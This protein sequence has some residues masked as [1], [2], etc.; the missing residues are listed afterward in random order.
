MSPF[1]FLLEFRYSVVILHKW[2][3]IRSFQWYIKK[4]WKKWTPLDPII[5]MGP[6]MD[7]LIAS[8]QK[9][10]HVILSNK[11]GI[12]W[13]NYELTT[14]TFPFRVSHFGFL[15]LISAIASWHLIINEQHW[16]IPCREICLQKWHFRSHNCRFSNELRSSNNCPNEFGSVAKWSHGLIF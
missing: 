5:K 9:S 11:Y 3:L 10:N 2:S 15:N 7:P 1:S 14:V 12:F 16:N 8:P 6:P 13:D 4:L